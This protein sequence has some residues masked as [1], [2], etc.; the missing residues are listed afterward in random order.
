M[1]DLC[2]VRSIRVRD[3]EHD[4][5]VRHV[6]IYDG[7]R[8]GERAGRRGRVLWGETPSPPDIGHDTPARRANA[9]AL[10]DAD[11]HGLLQIKEVNETLQAKL[12][13]ASARLR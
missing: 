6:R 5:P 3:G 12:S 2:S 1:L 4:S 10:L 8:E 11:L 9:I 13:V 7:A